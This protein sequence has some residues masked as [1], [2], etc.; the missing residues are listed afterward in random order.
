VGYDR[1]RVEGANFTYVNVGQGWNLIDEPEQGS[2]LIRPVLGAETPIPTKTKDP[3]AE[4][5]FV[6]IF[7]N[8]SRGKLYLRGVDGSV[9]DMAYVLYNPVGQLVA[10][11]AARS[12]LD[13]GSLPSGLYTLQIRDNKTGMLQINKVSLLR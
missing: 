7:P 13:F 9:E 8:P 6:N 1:N 5:D 2:L 3:I 4:R 10:R 12:E 11:G